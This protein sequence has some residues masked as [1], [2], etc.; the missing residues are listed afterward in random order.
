MP[1]TPSESTVRLRLH[2]ATMGTRWAVQ[3]DAPIGL[4]RAAL[5]QAL[6]AV[7]DAVDQQMSPWKTGSDL[8]RLNRA[9]V[10]DWV[11]LPCEIMQVLACALR[12][13]RASQGA[14]DIAAA[15]LVNAWGFGAPRS[16][17]DAAA[18]AAARAPGHV[19][20]HEALELDALGQRARKNAPA[21]FDLCGI[22]KGYA[23]DRMHAL[24][25][26]HGVAHALIAL[27]GELRALGPQAGG[28]PWAVAVE[29]PD[30]H[31]RSVHG[32]LELQDMAV[33]TS[34]NYRHFLQLGPARVAH[35][36]DTRR[37]APVANDVACVT[38]LAAQCMAADAW[39][40]ALLVAG[41]GPGLAL[42]QSQG[43]QALWLLRRAGKLVSLGMGRFAS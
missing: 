18:I 27:D 3:C 42:A 9:P 14:F 31:Q 19:A 41:P 1:K 7:V 8:M 10:G 24:L 40:T 2:G 39:A 22:A 5:Q 33:A 12:V 35:T 16:M 4:D 43:L 25:Q 6:A 36:M 29:A 28:E 32:V 15:A 34:G 11:Q 21:Q 17:P 38:V 13:G 37:G 20:A 23:V 30:A 26:A